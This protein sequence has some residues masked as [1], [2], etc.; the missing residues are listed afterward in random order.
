MEG[1]HDHCKIVIS[2][3]NPEKL[4]KMID[5]W[6]K[7]NNNDQTGQSTLTNNKPNTNKDKERKYFCNNPTC[8]KEIDKAVVAFCLHSDNKDRFK[9][10]V[11]CRECQ[12]KL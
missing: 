4:K 10:K 8:K 12:E 7:I 11:Y 5:Y 2:S 3:N 1:L 9:N 6:D